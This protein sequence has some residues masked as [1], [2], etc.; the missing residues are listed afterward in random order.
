M[1]MFQSYWDDELAQLYDVLYP[2]LWKSEAFVDILLQLAAEFGHPLLPEQRLLDVA[3]G[4][5]HPAYALLKKGFCVECSDGSGRML[6]RLRANFNSTDIPL[7]QLTCCTW[8]A[9]PKVFEQCAYD[10]VLCCGNSL[11]HLPP[12]SD[13]VDTAIRNLIHLLRP[14]GL[15]VVDAKKYNGSGEELN[16]ND[17]DANLVTRWY[18]RIVVPEREAGHDR[19]FHFLS[20]YGYDP[21]RQY[22][23]QVFEESAD[24]RRRK[25]GTYDFWAVDAQYL[26]ACLPILG[27]AKCEV[28][29]MRITGY[30]YDVVIAMR[31]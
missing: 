4:T 25:I 26:T 30:K 24:G 29:D 9:L 1:K 3:C 15:L 14:G 23:I 28:Y 18:R 17:G 21:N 7:P 19:V 22:I 27:A 13:G 6:E 5:G 16:L 31:D 10:V 8:H 12:R 11:A 2:G 20:N